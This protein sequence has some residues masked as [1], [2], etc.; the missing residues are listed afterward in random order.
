MSFEF[1]NRL[2]VTVRYVYLPL[3][4][5]AVT[6]IIII[7]AV[8]MSKKS[9][10]G[11]VSDSATNT[12]VYFYMPTCPHCIDFAPTWNEIKGKIAQLKQPI[13]VVEVDVTASKLPD[14]VP[15]G[16]VPPPFVPAIVVNKVVY[17]GKRTSVDIVNY[18][19]KNTRSTTKK[20]L[21]LF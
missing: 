2:P 17:Q 15:E 4:L 18:V 1:F 5:L 12:V 14:G 16:V 10:F 20:I 9:S 21:G 8:S 13:R 19:D 11:V 3:V 7:V 6:M